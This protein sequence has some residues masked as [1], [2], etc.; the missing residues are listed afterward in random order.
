MAW[1]TVELVKVVRHNQIWKIFLNH[2]LT[3]WMWILRKSEG[4]KKDSKVQCGTQ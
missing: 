3:D 1:T 2:S 4:V